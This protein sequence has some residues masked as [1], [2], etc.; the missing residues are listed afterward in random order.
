MTDA[1]WFATP[2]LG[3]YLSG[4]DIRGRD[5]HG[6]R[7]IDDS[8]LLV[9]HAGAGELEFTLPGDPWARWYEV[10]VDTTLD[11]DPGAHDDVV[12][13]GD[14]PV[15]LAPRSLLLLRADHELWNAT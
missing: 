4:Q 2:M 14:A 6:E 15:T 8:F 3:V 12:H 1:E 13:A 9:L 5:P 11:G 10:V 7:I